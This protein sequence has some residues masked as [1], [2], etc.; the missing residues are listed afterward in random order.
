VQ[1]EAR[2]Q[3]AEFT[4]FYDR[5]RMAKKIAALDLGSL[6]DSVRRVPLRRQFAEVQFMD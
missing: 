5:S 6:G 4:G 2:F 1:G 3:Q